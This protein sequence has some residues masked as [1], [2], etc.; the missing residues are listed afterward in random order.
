MDGNVSDTGSEDLR[1][2]QEYDD[3]GERLHETNPW[4]RD[5][6]QYTWEPAASLTTLASERVAEFEA[7]AAATKRAGSEGLTMQ[8]A[9]DLTV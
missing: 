2:I 4:I 9:V 6:N 7:A 3:V 5:D 1:A 8:S